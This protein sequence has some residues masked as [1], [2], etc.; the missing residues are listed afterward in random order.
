MGSVENKMAFRYP[1]LS[2]LF[3]VETTTI[4]RTTRTKVGFLPS[5]IL[6]HVLR[7]YFDRKK[8]PS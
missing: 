4:F 6:Y 3:L 2:V 7:K 1:T 5:H 8:I